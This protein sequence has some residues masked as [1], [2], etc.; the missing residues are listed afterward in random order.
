MEDLE[1]DLS[2]VILVDVTDEIVSMQDSTLPQLGIMDYIRPEASAFPSWW[3]FEHLS[4]D[5]WHP[6]MLPR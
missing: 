4:R 5:L 2:P 1:N 3:A 6:P